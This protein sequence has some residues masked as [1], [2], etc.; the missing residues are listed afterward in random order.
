MTEKDFQNLMLYTEL[1]KKF[2]LVKLDIK[3][4]DYSAL[5]RGHSFDDFNS[6]FSFVNK[7]ILHFNNKKAYK[8]LKYVENLHF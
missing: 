2:Y 3:K 5:I 1:E 6:A 8:K 7:K 4:P